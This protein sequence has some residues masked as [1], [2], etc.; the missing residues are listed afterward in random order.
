MSIYLDSLSAQVK[1][2]YNSVRSRL[3]ALLMEA[4]GQSM[5]KGRLI[6]LFERYFSAVS[7]HFNAVSTAC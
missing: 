5:E 3:K 4:A 1:L 2:D 6:V 7:A